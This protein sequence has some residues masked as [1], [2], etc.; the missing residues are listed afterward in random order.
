MEALRFTDRDVEIDESPMLSA[1]GM[2][3]GGES[4][5]VREIHVLCAGNLNAQTPTAVFRVS[6]L[7]GSHELLHRVKR[8]EIQ[9][10]NAASIL[11]QAFARHN[12][13]EKY[14]PEL[15]VASHVLSCDAITCVT[16][17]DLVR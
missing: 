14:G 11:T 13:G 2:V 15:F 17:L 5:T 1:V 12:I 7:R 10:A 3:L 9:W 4:V 8:V 6:V 16:R